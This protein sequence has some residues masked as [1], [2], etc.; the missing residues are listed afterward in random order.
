MVSHRTDSH[1]QARGRIAFSWYGMPQYAGRLI[2]AAIQALGQECV[3]LGSRPSVPVRGMDEAVGQ[4]IIWIEPS[5]ALRW[6]DLGIEV[7]SLFVQSGWGYRAFAAL[8]REVKAQ[9]GRV[10]CMSDA[11]W[12]GDFR[13]LILGPLMFRALYRHRFDAMLVPGQEGRRLMRWFGMPNARVRMGM[14][15]ADA[16]L[17]TAGPA[18]AARPKTFLFVG[19]FIARK[20]VLGLVR[21]FIRFSENQP[22][23]ELRLCGSGEQRNLIPRHPRIQVED[24]VQPEHLSQRLHGA[25]FLVLPSLVEAWGLVVHEAALCGC[26]LVLSSAVGSAIDLAGRANALRFPAGN[27][28]ELLRALREAAEFDEQRLACAEAESISLALRFGPHRFASEINSLV[29]ELL[30]NGRTGRQL[31]GG[32]APAIAPR[33]AVSREDN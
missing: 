12:R 23:W 16:S 20:D 29:D 26:G 30:V 24:F 32:A 9:G 25:R 13:Q 28:N 1:Q 11:N 21:A 4:E 8:G 15:G 31:P 7:P 10:I 5:K 19:Q 27:E 17:F 33:D 18:L 6:H 3:V 22:D 2:K 14:Y